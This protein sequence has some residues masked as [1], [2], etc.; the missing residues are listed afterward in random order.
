MPVTL[1]P[2]VVASALDNTKSCLPW[3]RS[4]DRRDTVSLRSSPPSQPSPRASFVGSR[5]GSES[6]FARI[7]GAFR[8]RFR[9]AESVSGLGGSG[10]S[11][12]YS[13]LSVSSASQT[14]GHAHAHGLIYG[15][16]GESRS[17]VELIPW[18]YATAKFSP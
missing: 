9:F 10:S 6:F 3:Q 15:I 11:R 16:G 4:H 17:S 7:G 12:R 13:H 5:N 1:L 18:A 14:L 8:S 2:E